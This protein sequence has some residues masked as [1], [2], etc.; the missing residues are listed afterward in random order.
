M[1]KKKIQY[2]YQWRWRVGS[3]LQ[4][5][6]WSNNT[7]WTQ[8]IRRRIPMDTSNSHNNSSNSSN[9]SRAL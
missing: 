3:Y 7:V 4:S 9:H 2:R 5:G 6:K 1:V 8:G